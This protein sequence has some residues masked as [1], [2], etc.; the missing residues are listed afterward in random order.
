MNDAASASDII[1]RMLLSQSFLQLQYSSPRWTW[2][3]VCKD[4]FATGSWL[5]ESVDSNISSLFFF[6]KVY[7]LILLMV[8]LVWITAFCLYI[9]FSSLLFSSHWTVSLAA[10]VLLV[11]WMMGEDIV[12]NR[13]TARVNMMDSIMHQELR[14]P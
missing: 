6:P 11:N 9:M 1:C 8:L 7:H 2:I 14:Y 10:S 13:I 3:G 5:C 12:L 4:L